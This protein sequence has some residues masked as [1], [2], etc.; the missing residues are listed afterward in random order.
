MNIIDLLEQLETTL[1]KEW[2]QDDSPEMSDVSQENASDEPKA[3]KKYSFRSV[4]SL[5]F[6]FVIDAIKIPFLWTARFLKQELIHAIK[7]DLQNMAL[8]GLLLIILLIFFAVLWF[9]V[10]VLIGVFFY[11]K[12]NALL[13][14][15][16]YVVIFQLFSMMAVGLSI[17]F[18]AKKRHAASMIHKISQAARR[19]SAK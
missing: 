5:L 12:G 14:S 3:R 16:L 19:A 15:V 2:K 9:S 1:H 11:E 6:S 10:S 17:Y 4:M 7:K 13:L 8:I 18:I